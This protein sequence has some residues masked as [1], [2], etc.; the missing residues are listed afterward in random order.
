MAAPAPPW[1][2][3]ATFVE[4]EHLDV[5]E[6]PVRPELDLRWRT[7]FDRKMFGLNVNDEIVAV[8]GLAF[9]NDVPCSVR[10]LD[11]MSRLSVHEDNATIA[12]AYTVWSKKRGCGKRIMKEVLRYAR[13]E[14]FQRVVTLS[15]LTPMATHFH[16]RNEARLIRLNE[17]TQNF[18]YRL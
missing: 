14:G 13:T 12:V 4:L 16:I 7:Q 11:L 2:E 17:T 15:P 5:S 1:T 10:E 8:V 3:R 9:T 18:E 6:D